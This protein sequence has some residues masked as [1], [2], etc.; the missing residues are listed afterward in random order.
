MPA[1]SSNMKN[2]QKCSYNREMIKEKGGEEKIYSR[3]TLNHYQQ[4]QLDIRIHGRAPQS[5]I[6]DRMRYHGVYH[7]IYLTF[8]TQYPDGFQQTSNKT[9]RRAVSTDNLG[10]KCFLRKKKK[11]KKIFQKTA[12]SHFHTRYNCDTIIEKINA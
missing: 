12:R 4:V 5:G 7:A 2:A 11:E 8:R 9:H 6:G 1:I 10:E 3:H